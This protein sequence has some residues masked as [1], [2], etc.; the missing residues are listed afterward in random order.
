[1]MG[2]SGCSTSAWIK[3]R[4][5]RP[6]EK[7]VFGVGPKTCWKEPIVTVDKPGPATKKKRSRWN[8]AVRGKYGTKRGK[9]LS[10][11]NK[12]CCERKKVP[13]C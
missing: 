8:N 5:R 1:M 3:R 12:D 9:K 6:D 10:E 11:K 7:R 13:F 4:K 2:G